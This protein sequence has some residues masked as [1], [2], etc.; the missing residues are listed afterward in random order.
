MK[1][2]KNVTSIILF[3]IFAIIWNTGVINGIN[4]LTH[5]ALSTFFIDQGLPWFVIAFFLIMSLIM[6]AI[7]MP[8][9]LAF[10]IILKI[11]KAEGKK[12][13]IIGN[14]GLD[15]FEFYFSPAIALALNFLF[16]EMFLGFNLSTEFGEFTIL[17]WLA[18]FALVYIILQVFNWINKKLQI[19]LKKIETKQKKF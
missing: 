16:P 19:F 3:F 14:Q 17:Y 11:M 2:L 1:K 18:L 13:N 7:T 15:L 8:V 10:Y 5:S 6:I 4:L 9:F 12:A